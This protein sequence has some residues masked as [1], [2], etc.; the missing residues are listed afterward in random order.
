MQ[1]RYFATGTLGVLSRAV[2]LAAFVLLV[3]PAGRAADRN[4]G[5]RVRTG[6]DPSTILPVDLGVPADCIDSSPR[7]MN[8]GAWPGSLVVGG[9][10]NCAGN[11]YLP[12]VWRSGTWT[13]VDLPSGVNAQGGW[14]SSVSDDAADEPA[15]TLEVMFNG[16]NAAWVK[17]AGQPVAALPLHNGFKV[18]TAVISAQGLHSVG[19]P[20]DAL[21]RAVRW[22]RAGSDWLPPVDLGTGQAVASSG[23]GSVVVGNAGPDS[24]VWT[25]GGNRQPLGTKTQAR[26]ITH[27]GSMIVGSR[28]AACPNKPA[29]CTYPIPVYWAVEGGQWSMHDLQALDGVDSEARAVAEVHG[30]HVIAGFGYTNQDGG[31]LRPVAWVPAADGSYGAPLRLEPLGGDFKSWAEAVDVN[32]NGLVLGWSDRSATDWTTTAVVWPL[33]EQPTFRINAGIGGAWYDP[34]TSGQGQFIDVEPFSR[35]MFVSWFTYTDATAAHPGQQ[36]WFT[37]QGHFEDDVAEL[38]VY[39]TL[40]GRFD[41]PQAVSTVPVGEATLRFIDCGLGEMT[42]E[43]EAWDLQ[44]SFALQRV[45]PDSQGSCEQIAG[46]ATRAVDINAGMDGAWYE[47]DTGGQGFFIDAHPD[48]QGG[49]FIFVSWFTFGDQTASGQRWLTAQGNFTGATATIDVSETTGGFFD[50]PGAVVNTKV[51]TMTIDFTDCSHAILSY[52]L[53]D[54]GV[55]GSIDISRVVPGTE[56]LCEELVQAR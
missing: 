2:F 48:P 24:W 10:S 49:N 46:S 45:I 43:I 21:G 5:S 3:P 17:H 29:G 28:T 26:D 9:G 6:I 13:P 37:A 41:D 18:Q 11:K 1:G 44:G 27:S 56:K 25:E 33:F 32:R 35:F 39:E 40:G 19:G 31:I 55:E 8:N 15:M 30:M 53:T 7:A 12:Q 42:Y 22:T 51:G 23:D 16:Y 54:D 38:T 20:A 4:D 14:V 50:A 47:P 34:A 52:S 36:H